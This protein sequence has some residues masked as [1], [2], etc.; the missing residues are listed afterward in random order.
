MEPRLKFNLKHKQNPTR[1][2]TSSMLLD[3]ALLPMLAL[4]FVRNLR[5][6]DWGSCCHQGL[7]FRGGSTAT[8]QRHDGTKHTP[9]THSRHMGL[10][11]CHVMSTST[12]D[13]KNRGNACKR[14]R[15]PKDCVGDYAVY[16][17]IMQC[18]C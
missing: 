15:A 4:T 6:V 14:I 7:G 17:L 3:T 5:P 9:R 2:R 13:G 10:A 1:S 11:H 16:V 18:V 8:V 12:D